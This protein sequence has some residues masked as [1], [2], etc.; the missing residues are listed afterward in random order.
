MVCVLLVWLIK[1]GLSELVKIFIV[2]LVSLSL[3]I[4]CVVCLWGS[5]FIFYFSK[6]FYRFVRLK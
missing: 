2:C 1:C 5:V 6:I 3:M 4:Y